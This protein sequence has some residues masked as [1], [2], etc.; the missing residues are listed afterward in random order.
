MFSTDATKKKDSLCRY[1]NDSPKDFANAAV[2]WVVILN[3]VHI[4]LFANADICRG[5]ETM[6]VRLNYFAFFFNKLL[7]LQIS[8][9]LFFKLS[10]NVFVIIQLSENISGKSISFSL[11]NQG[12]DYVLWRK[13]SGNIRQF[14]LIVLDR[15]LHRT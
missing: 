12:K 9:N 7:W 4:C 6:Y 5:T 11:E 3:K 15:I 1:V 13:K 14:M 10:Q 2:R 8:H